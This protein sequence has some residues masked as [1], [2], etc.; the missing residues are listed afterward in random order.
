MHGDA[1]ITILGPGGVGAFIGAALARAGEDVLLIARDPTAQAIER[2]GL[3]VESARLGTLL[4]QPKPAT[5]LDRP[6]DVLIVA[7]KA[8]DLTTALE[9]V[10]E[11]PA[12]VVPLLNGLDHLDLLRER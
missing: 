3:T 5:Q 11:E 1:L 10:Q 7:T 9:R 12:L 6:T 2:D 8:K 4:T